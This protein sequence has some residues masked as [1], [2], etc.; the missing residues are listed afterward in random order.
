MRTLT[1]G[2]TVRVRT[3]VLRCEFPRSAVRCHVAAEALKPLGRVTWP[4]TS[5]VLL[6]LALSI[7]LGCALAAVCRAW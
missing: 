4:R 3:T 1:P 6:T 2:L 7:V 5:L